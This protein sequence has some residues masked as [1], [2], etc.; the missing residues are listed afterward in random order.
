MPK[1]L[2]PLSVFLAA[3]G[4]APAFAQEA[5]PAYSQPIAQV[6]VAFDKDGITATRSEG[7]ADLATKRAVT[8]DDPVRIASI[9]KFVTSIAA[10]KL[11]EEKKIDLDADVSKYLGFKLRNPNF[12]RDR[13]TLRMMLS[14]TSSLTDGAGYWQVPADGSYRDMILSDPK[15]WDAQH[16]PGSY[17]RYTNLN[18]PLIGQ[19]L[20]A[21][22][23]ER[24]DLLLQRVVLKPL[25]IDACYGW[26]TCD[27]AT[28]A[29]AVVLYENG[30]PEVDDNRGKKPACGVTRAKDGSC[31]LS[32]YKPGTQGGIFG[33]QGGLRISANGL[34]KI[35]R[36][37]LNDGTVDGVQIL[38]PESV[39]TMTVPQWTLR[40]GNGFTTEEDDPVR[41][42]KGE[43]CRYGLAT[44][45]LATPGP[46]CGDDPFGDGIARVGHSGNAYGMLAGLWL[47]REHGTG[48]AYFSTGNDHPAPGEHSAFSAI[49]ERQAQGR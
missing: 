11:V 16:R 13:I 20:E 17:W 5:A 46:N 28:A 19:A 43:F 42:A 27:E 29:R 41:N 45:T 47:D 3:L 32:N 31:D 10:M 8:A 24:F 4:C 36:M 34:A 9:S 18:F 48:V 23:G 21:A 26:I 6:R 15:A 22:S 35:G 2:L 14:H 49:E 39:R 1:R 40:D 12:P 25:G 33:P 37:L 7:F 30:K 44:Q 38:K